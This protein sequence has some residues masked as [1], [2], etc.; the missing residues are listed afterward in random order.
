MSTRP[1][2]APLPSRAPQCLVGFVDPSGAP[3]NP[4]W[5]LRDMLA[6]LAHQHSALLSAFVGLRVLCWRDTAYSRLGTVAGRL[7]AQDTCAHPAA[8]GWEK[9]PQGKLAP[10]MADLAPTMDPKRYVASLRVV[11]LLVRE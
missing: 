8:V 5:P 6:Y 7:P 11:W 10:C 2:V 4:G 9:N 3:S 1:P